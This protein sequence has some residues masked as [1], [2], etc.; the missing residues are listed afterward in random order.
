[1]RLTRML[2]SPVRPQSLFHRRIRKTRTPAAPRSFSP[3]S[4]DPISAS[5]PS[6]RLLHARHIRR[7]KDDLFVLRR[8][9]WTIRTVALI[10]LRSEVRI[11]FVL[12]PQPMEIEFRKSDLRTHE[13]D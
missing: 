11:V 1:M 3:T 12:L 10:D 7:G 9:L 5:Q 13:N 2:S 6:A 4:A 8:T